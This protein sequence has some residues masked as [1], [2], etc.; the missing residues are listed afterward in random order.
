MC[1]LATP[2][3]LELVNPRMVYSYCT[4]NAPSSLKLSFLE[5]GL[6]CSS[7]SYTQLHRVRK[8]KGVEQSL[9]GPKQMPPR[10]R[11][12]IHDAS[13]GQ[14]CGEQSGQ[15]PV[16]NPEYRPL[17]K[18]NPSED[19]QVRKSLRTLMNAAA[20]PSSLISLTRTSVCWYRR[21]IAAEEDLPRDTGPQL[22]AI[23]V[24]VNVVG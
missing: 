17:S 16:S 18:T 1:I 3:C 20:P 12:P 10:P 11:A 23:W 22:A 21:S 5:I 2:Y 14:R 4:S 13:K 8:H 7:I 24:K 19:P 6:I 9:T 15:I